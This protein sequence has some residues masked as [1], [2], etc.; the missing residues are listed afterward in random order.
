MSCGTGHYKNLMAQFN[1]VVEV[2]LAQDEHYQ[3]VIADITRRMGE[4]M[5]EFIPK[6]VGR[7]AG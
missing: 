1:T 5:A 2:F 6:E 3:E 4:G 7:G